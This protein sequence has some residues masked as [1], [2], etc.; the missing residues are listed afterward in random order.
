MGLWQLL[1]IDVST[2]L[3]LPRCS[4]VATKI[5]SDIDFVAIRP[6]GN[7]LTREISEGWQYIRQRA[8][9]RHLTMYFAAVNLGVG[10][11]QP[12][13]TP[14]LLT[15][16][17]VRVL[18][19]VMSAAVYGNVTGRYPRHLD[20]GPSSCRVDAVVTL[21]AILGIGVFVCGLKASYVLIGIG[22]GIAFFCIPIIEASS[23]AVWQRKTPPELPRQGLRYP[24][25]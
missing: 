24:Q 22:V 11:V 5:N 18:G 17:S 16:A 23:Q 9:L 12:L 25:G 20:W 13:L 14:L 4:Q 7:S 3:F 6:D 15:F 1:L 10:F 2:Y 19:Y 21:T 8:G